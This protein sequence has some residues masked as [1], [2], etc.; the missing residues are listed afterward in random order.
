MQVQL[1][2]KMKLLP[3]LSGIRVRVLRWKRVMKQLK[4]I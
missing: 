4:E 1:R 3:N 2:I